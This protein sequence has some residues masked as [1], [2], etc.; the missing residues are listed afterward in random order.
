[1]G[2]LID[3]FE[4]HEGPV[5]SVNFHPTQPLFVSGGDDYTIKVW[6]TLTRKCIFT[7]LGHLDYVRTV[8]FHSELPWILSTSDDQTIRIWNWQNRQEIACL[9]GH[10]H[11]VMLAEFHP[12]QDLIVSA[13]LDQTVRV[14][15]ILGLRK[16]HS[17]PGNAARSFEDQLL[18]Q[19]M[20]QQDIFGNTD[21]VVKFVLE[22][23]DRGVNWAAFHP[24]LPL[25]VSG[26]D[27]R[28]VKLW[29]M[30]ETKAWEVDT[31]R[32]HTNNVL[33]VLFHPTQDLIISVSED[34][35]IRTWDLNRRTAIKQYTRENDRFWL[36][37]AH[38]TINLFAAAHDS[39][40]MVF[41]LGRERPPSTIVHN[42]LFY[43]NGERQVQ[44]YNFEKHEANPPVLSLKKVGKPWTML[45]SLLYNPLEHLVL[46][47]TG[48]ED[49]P[50]YALIALPKEFNFAIEP[51]S[52]RQDAA[53]FAVFVAR[54]RFVTYSKETGILAVKDLNNNVTK[55]IKLD[56]PVKDVLYAGPGQVLL[57]RQNSVV[58]FDVQQKKALGE[59]QVANVKYAS[60]SADGEHVA[61]LLKHT[62]TI[63]SKKLELVALMHETIRI[64]SAAWDDSGVLLYLTLNHI[65]YTLLNGDSGIIKTLPN[66]VYLVKVTGKNVF[67]LTRE[68]NVETIKIDPTEYRFKK[69]LVNRNFNEVLRIIKNLT[70]V[71]Q[72]IIAYLQKKGYPEIALQFVQDPETRFELSIESGDLQTALTEAQKLKLP[73]AWEALGKEALRHGDFPIAELVYQDQKQLEQ[74]SFLYLVN[75][76]VERLRKMQT[77]AEHR[78]DISSL[79]QNSVYLNSVEKR[80]NVFA[81]AGSLPIAY[82]AAVAN[83]LEPLAEK[84]LAAAGIDASEVELPDDMGAPLSLPKA[85][86]KLDRWPL[87]AAGPSFFEQVVMGQIEDLSLEEEPEHEDEEV[88]KE[89]A[90][91]FLADEDVDDDMGWDEG[92]DISDV[93]D[94]PET[95]EAALTEE[96][97][98]VQNAPLNAAVHVAAGQFDSAAQL[99]HRQV[100]VVDFEPLRLRFLEVYEAAR[101]YV[102]GAEGVPPVVAYVRADPTEESSLK[103]KPYIPGI[104][105]LESTL[106]E[107]FRLFKANKLQEAI[108][109]FRSVIYTVAVSAVDNEDDEAKCKEALELC[110]EYILGL[111]I[112]LARRELPADEVKRNLELAAYFTKAKLRPAHRV[113]A[114]QVAMT[115]S[116]KKKN[117]ALASYFAAEILKI[118]PLGP[119]AESAQKVRAKSDSIGRDEIEIDFDPYAEF[120]VC[121]STFTPIYDG[122]PLAKESL[123]GALYQ[124]SEKGKVCKITGITQIG[125]QAS[126]LRLLV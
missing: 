72:N 40:V 126:G 31:C 79:I 101:L 32:G 81:Q 18:R 86:R 108:D 119:R 11:Y 28:V 37:A 77:I 123:V 113:N 74:L 100:G 38:P 19:S 42:Q 80:A 76:D 29:R 17:A 95:P 3:R 82:A 16:K 107:A 6:L 117:Y 14:W 34:K 89:S 65:K 125:A 69:A 105:S 94:G 97:T 53:D 56:E 85:S 50:M 99:L 2:T 67:C 88:V 64:K 43:L 41:K 1:M 75:G 55:S 46:V 13:S 62:I 5:R 57:L 36:V 110:R 52:M 83:G 114:L 106:L 98:W 115:Q 90:D 60:W 39:G 78:T 70:L 20:P 45:R 8:L 7:L 51:L 121:A 68:G 122:S 10:N 48:P 49:L 21:A 25:I 96:A 71:G 9:T 35:T 102:P 12:T 120:T 47:T 33:A 111:L 103:F 84:V 116:F 26:G 124:S 73:A 109:V 59:I 24:K 58:L 118:I 4:E 66:T 54:N 104:D 44:T 92:L 22:G 15:D 112:E 91:A 30:S 63:A 61:L 23:H 87:K 27:D 93:E